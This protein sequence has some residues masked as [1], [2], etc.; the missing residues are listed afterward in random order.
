MWRI[1]L[2]HNEKNK[3]IVDKKIFSKVCVNWILK[4]IVVTT[5]QIKKR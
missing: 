4:S 1:H 5:R 2:K 3:P